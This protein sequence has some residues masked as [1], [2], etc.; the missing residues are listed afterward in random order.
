MSAVTDESRRTKEGALIVPVE[1]IDIGDRLRFGN[2]WLPVIE[3]EE[4]PK[5]RRIWCQMGTDLGSWTAR[6]STGRMRRTTMVAR[7]PRQGTASQ[8][9]DA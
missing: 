4:Y 9:A 8:Q 3:I 5:T 6:T 7:A 1:E 2:L